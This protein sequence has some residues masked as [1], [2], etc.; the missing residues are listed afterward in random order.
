M[1]IL[2]SMAP[3]AQLNY[4]FRSFKNR[5]NRTYFVQMQS[6]VSAGSYMSYDARSFA[7]PSSGMIL[8]SMAPSAHMNY[9]A[10]SGTVPPARRG[11][12]VHFPKGHGNRRDTEMISSSTNQRLFLH[13]TMGAL[14]KPSGKAFGCCWYVY[15]SDARL[16][17]PIELTQ[18]AHRWR[19]TPGPPPVIPRPE[20]RPAH[21][22]SS[23]DY[24][25]NG[26]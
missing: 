1:M 8:H 19:P 22:T 13:P 7:G 3:S 25:A 6:H 21:A 24:I 10:C 26:T 14:Q 17:T 2:H 23:E 15:Y 18:C 9:A 20:S 5:P 11:M 16:L 4:A 12:G